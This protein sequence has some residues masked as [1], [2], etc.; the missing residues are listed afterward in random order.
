MYEATLLDAIACGVL[1]MASPY[2]EKQDAVYETTLLYAFACHVLMA[3]AW[4]KKQEAY[5]M[6]TLPEARPRCEDDSP[7][8]HSIGLPTLRPSY[9]LFSRGA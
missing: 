6:M 2:P 8:V 9:A 5:L 7:D 3:S 1:M 4:P